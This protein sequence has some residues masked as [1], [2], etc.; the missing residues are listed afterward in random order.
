MNPVNDAAVELPC[1]LSFA[2][3]TLKYGPKKAHVF[4]IF[5]EEEVLLTFYTADFKASRGQE[6]F[7]SYIQKS[8]ETYRLLEL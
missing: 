8:H 5:S 4:D 3:L 6:I 1:A 2:R 7:E